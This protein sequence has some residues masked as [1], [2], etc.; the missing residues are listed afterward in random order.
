MVGRVG[1]GMR[2]RFSLRDDMVYSMP[3]HFSGR[4]FE[5][6]A[7]EYGDM[8]CVRLSF[9]TDPE[10]L[11]NYLPGCFE[12]VEPRVD[13]QYASCRDVKWMSGGDYR[14]LQVTVPARY[15]GE[16]EVIT[17]D[18]A[19]VVWEDKA[20]PIIGGREEDGV[21]KLFAQIA[22]ERHV[23][24]HW[25]TS[26]A[27]ESC[28]FCSLDFWGGE[29]ISDEDLAGMNREGRVNLFGWRYIPNLGGPGGALSQ[30]TLYPQRVSFRSAQRGMGL[31]SWTKIGFERHPVQWRIIDALADMPV[32]GWRGALMT[33]GSA[34]LEVGSSRAL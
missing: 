30:P 4:A 8:T 32:L 26:A 29:R 9:E 33:W 5:P 17:G 16:R 11:L 3:V 23:G 15:V 28:Q 1:L 19:L 21:P 31:V 18:Y 14:L 22:S 10:V 20:C 34:V 24:D 6:V 7:A 27:Y 25:F 13:V 12:L 2:G